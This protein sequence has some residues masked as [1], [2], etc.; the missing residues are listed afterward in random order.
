[1]PFNTFLLA[2]LSFFLCL[3]VPSSRLCPCGHGCFPSPFFSPPVENPVC[4]G[5]LF[6]VPSQ[7]G[8]FVPLKT[9]LEVIRTLIP[10]RFFPFVPQHRITDLFLFPLPVMWLV[11]VFLHFPSFP[12]LAKE[13]PSVA[14]PF[15][16]PELIVPVESAVSF[17]APCAV[18]RCAVSRT[19]P[20]SCLLMLGP[21]NVLTNPSLPFFLR[22]A[23]FYLCGLRGEFRFF[24]LP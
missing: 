15:P 3:F 2:R 24:L 22:P 1:L 6:G 4:S 16:P 20:F 23:V 18:F 10:S 8:D 17:A 13:Y 7:D 9:I 5:H 21:K 12:V 11:T 19:V 14:L